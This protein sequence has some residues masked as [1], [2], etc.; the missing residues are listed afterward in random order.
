MTSVICVR[1]VGNYSS[2]HRAFSRSVVLT[3]KLEA[4]VTLSAVKYTTSTTSQSGEITILSKLATN[5]ARY[6][7]MP[8]V[9]SVVA[10]RHFNNRHKEIR[11]QTFS[12]SAVALNLQ[13]QKTLQGK[14]SKKGGLVALP[15]QAINM[16]SSYGFIDAPA[17]VS[18]N[19]NRHCSISTI[20]SKT[21][22]SRCVDPLTMSPGQQ[23][24]FF[25]KGKDKPKTKKSTIVINPEEIRELINYDAFHG[26][27][28]TLME[29]MKEEFTK[30]LNV[31]GAAGMY[32]CISNL[33]VF[34]FDMDRN[35]Y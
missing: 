28:E 9:T 29:E 13:A 32:L 2:C 18:T 20:F 34:S 35:L 4:V 33:L 23:R 26:Q 16:P 19:S 5:S 31:R 3:T 27:L 7:S 30:H 1:S 10:H 14:Q 17:L 12:T 8:I 21:K 6:K 24:R 25:A 15:F 11:V 22:L